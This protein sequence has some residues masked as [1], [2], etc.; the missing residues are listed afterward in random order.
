MSAPMKKPAF[1]K[2]VV[3]ITGAAKGIG[4]ATAEEFGRA[5]ATLVLTDRD[6]EA[7]LKASDELRALG[8]AVH[9]RVVDVTDQ[10]AVEELAGWVERTLGGLDILVN[11][12]GVG[13]QGALAETSM[14]TWRRL[15]DVNFWGPLYHVYAFLPSMIKRRRGYIVNVSSGQA[16][17]RLPTW[18]AY[19]AVKVALGAF[20]EI[21][22]FELR[23]HGIRVT[24]VYPFMVNTPF[25]EGMGGESL[26][27]RLSMQLLPYYSMTPARVGRIIVEAIGRRQPV[28]MV[29]PIN[30]I[31]HI[32]HLLPPVA[33]AM[34][35]VSD[36]VLSKESAHAA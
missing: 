17:F 6:E 26:G 20:S 1:E 34:S 9:N 15:V 21:L 31:G 25:Y 18:G 36:R 4:R 33:N 19:A 3:L 7:L 35:W 2:K 28:V 5:G 22:R 32:M 14:E 30:R 16:F 24:T 11:N 29:S 23:K 12:A 10:Q 27:A 8:A 13:Y